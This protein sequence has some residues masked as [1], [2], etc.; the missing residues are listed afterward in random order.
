MWLM[1]QKKTPDDYVIGTGKTYSVRDFVK[2]AFSHVGLDYKKYVKIDK[3]LLRPAEVDLLIADYKKAKKNLK[4][5]PKT[6]F[7]QL[8]IN[9][10]SADL[11]FV[12]KQGY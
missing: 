1:L 8:V 11:E 3:N 10:V 4:W 12:K 5:Y 6:H 7:K 9:M 2:T